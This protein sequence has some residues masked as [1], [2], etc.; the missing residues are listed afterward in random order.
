MKRI[1]VPLFYV[2]IVVLVSA[3]QNGALTSSTISPT[4]SASP[5]EP[6]PSDSPADNLSEKTDI[7]KHSAEVDKTIY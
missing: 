2:F 1:L 4:E 5:L 3:C 6:T 7:P